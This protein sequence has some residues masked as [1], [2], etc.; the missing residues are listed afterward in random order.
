MTRR[1]FLQALA[2]ASVGLYL[3]LK[4]EAVAEVAQVRAEP[5]KRD[6][7][8]EFLTVVEPEDNPRYIM[9]CKDGK[10]AVWVICK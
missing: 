1:T 9:Y 4:P 2:V 8:A 7:L 5:R 3:R 10:P 6:E